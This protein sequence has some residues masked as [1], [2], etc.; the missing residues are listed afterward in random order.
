MVY[1]L[2]IFL[3][4]VVPSTTLGRALVMPYAIIG[5]ISL[6]LLVSSIRNI[7]V[8]RAHVRKKLVSLM[9]KKQQ[10]RLDFLRKRTQ[11]YIIPKP[12]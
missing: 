2:R 3:I 5:I 1:S 6:G 7:V 9:L 10:K 8:E 12:N 4:K 11:R